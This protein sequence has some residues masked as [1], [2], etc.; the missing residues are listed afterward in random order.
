MSKFI[1]RQNEL[2]FLNSKYGQKKSNLII[3][4]GKR[5]VGKT[6]LIK[7]FIKNK[8]GVYFLADRRTVKD[9]LRELSQLFA[10]HFKDEFIARNSFSDWLDVFIY[11]KDNVKDDFVFVVDEFP[12]LIETDHSVNSIFQK[13]WDEYLKD[14]PIFMILSGSSIAMMESE[15]LGYNA[16]LYG[17]RS[18]QILVKPLT[19]SQ[20]R[21]FFQNDDF[22]K[23]LSFYTLTGG[24]PAYILEM[25]ENL[26]I[27]TNLK[28]KILN[29]NEFL[30]NEVE[31]ILREEL[32]E[33]RIY[34]S[35]LKAIS[36]GKTR[37]SEIINETGIEKNI[38]H[39]YL[40]V[41]E[42]LQLI[43]REIPITEDNPE[44]SKKG[45]YKIRDNFF[46]I[47]FQ[48]VYPYKSNL[49]VGEYKEVLNK[50]NSGFQIICG[51][52]FEQVSIEIV[53]RYQKQIFNFERIGRWWDNNVE[54]D[55][56][57]LNNESKKILFG[58]CK[59]SNKPV[60][61]NILE[62]LINKAKYVNWN[63]TVRKEYYVLL[64]KSGFTDDL[65]KRTEIQSN[66]Y[67]I[68]Q[69]KILDNRS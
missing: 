50:F 44:K 11:L 27:F 30:Y 64:S 68:T 24:M 40:G 39:K 29:K 47:W 4:Y 51:Y 2:K 42:H 7:Q 46:N 55:I 14:I 10:L 53:K 33:P 9:Q 60:G 36:W 37:A 61:V 1:N 25:S 17:R 69:D 62:D 66:I 45:I 31:F 6:E 28:N 12:Y 22:E 43:E 52:I 16:P 67:L 59:W 15:V 26:S 54:I 49:E 18:G 58:E 35:I 8:N 3:V 56:V 65:I 32:R 5:R 57:G 19:F 13:G 21:E 38:L 48:Y 41:L 63:N 20:S 23:H 34:L